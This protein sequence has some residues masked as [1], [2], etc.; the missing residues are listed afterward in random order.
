[1]ES[2]DTQWT[3]ALHGA[4]VDPHQSQC[5]GLSVLCDSLEPVTVKADASGYTGA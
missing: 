1:M 3:M 2:V 4:Y 5:Q